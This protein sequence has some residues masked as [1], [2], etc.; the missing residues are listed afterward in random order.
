V[1]LK[2]SQTLADVKA[3]AGLTR[4]RTEILELT[5]VPAICVL[6]QRA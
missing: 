3:Q 1:V 2:A 5:S 6:A 4:I